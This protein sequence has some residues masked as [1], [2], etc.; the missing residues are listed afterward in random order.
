MLTLIGCIISWH[1]SLFLFA[2]SITA[3]LL[4]VEVN[5]FS[6]PGTT[7]AD[8]SVIARRP[9]AI[10]SKDI[11][12]DE[13][14]KELQSQQPN[15]DAKP[16]DLNDQLYLQP[17]TVL[18][19]PKDVGRCT[20]LVVHRHFDFFSLHDLFPH[21]KSLS[22]QF[23][24]NIN[25]RNDLRDAIRH[26]MMFGEWS[27]YSYLTNEQKH[28]ELNQ[29]Q[30]MIGLWK[31]PGSEKDLSQTDEQADDDVRMKETTKV[32]RSYLLG[33]DTAQVP[34]GD[35]LLERIGS[36]CN[37]AE[38][39]FH[40]TEVVGVAATQNHR[41]GDKTDHAWHQDYGCL[42]EVISSRTCDASN[43]HVF[44][45]FPCEDH[46]HGT[47]VFPHLI[48]LQHEQWAMRQAGTSNI[49]SSQKPIFYRGKVPE[50]YIVRPWY[51]PGREI[52]VF[53][54]VDVLHS[55]PDIQYRSSIMR[56]G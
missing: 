9:S 6:V 8:R 40:W 52:I 35:E 44:W 20:M 39:P 12:G 26:D 50:Q 22:D 32:L 47:G 18:E 56:F 41:M 15:E 42:E 13:L 1:F 31:I 4:A 36:L 3:I 33:K 48:P 30:P 51:A 7:S 55:T 10:S 37:S 28:A 2:W 43:K 17:M 29:Q 21:T 24:A 46:Y 19:E 45:G 38:A 34:T 25:F 16:Y 23:H 53:R 11:L 27:V 54:D 5:A 14:R 49:S